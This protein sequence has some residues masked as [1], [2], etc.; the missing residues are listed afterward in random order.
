M[1]WIITSTRRCVSTVISAVCDRVCVCVSALWTIND[2]SYQ[3][4]RHTCAWQ[5]LGM[6][7]CW[8]QKVKV[9]GHAVH[10]GCAGR[11]DCLV[12]WKVGNL[13]MLVLYLCKFP[14]VRRCKAIVNRCIRRQC[15]LKQSVSLYFSRSGYNQVTDPVENFVTKP[16]Q[17]ARPWLVIVISCPYC[18]HFIFSATFSQHST[19]WRRTDSAGMTSVCL[20]VCNVGGLWSL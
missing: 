16:T 19:S 18:A 12:R 10:C 11:Y 6:D 1:Q 5:S 13:C 17:A 4:G 9:Q 3:H 14:T 20:S 8:G 7:W 2:L 15:T